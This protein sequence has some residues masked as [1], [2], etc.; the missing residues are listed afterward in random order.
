MIK[1][2]NKYIVSVIIVILF[3][4]IL[5]NRD[6]YNNIS[7]NDTYFEE[8]A[9]K[10][11]HYHLYIP[12][13]ST[14]VKIFFPEDISKYDFTNIKIYLQD[15]LLDFDYDIININDDN[16]EIILREYTE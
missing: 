2:V 13:S 1:I 4:T 6:K 10:E 3:G 11:K 5:F 12:N 15:E 7:F 16:I 14:R 9:S 8:Y